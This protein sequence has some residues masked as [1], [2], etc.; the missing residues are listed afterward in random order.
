MNQQETFVL[1]VRPL[2]DYQHRHSYPVNHSAHHVP[3]APST[4]ASLLVQSRNLTSH[5]DTSDLPQLYLGLD[6]VEEQSRKLVG[7][8]R[9]A[10]ARE[11]G[12][13]GRA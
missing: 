7:K 13:E 9:G 4:L 3:M 10:G 5:L 12:E 6:Q 2:L 8:G 1:I 11:E